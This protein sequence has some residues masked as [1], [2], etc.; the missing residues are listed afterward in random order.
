MNAKYI[1]IS[2]CALLAIGVMLPFADSSAVTCPSGYNMVENTGT[3]MPSNNGLPSASVKDIVEN[4]LKW[5]LGLF[6]VIG[7][8]AFVISG[9]MYL[10]AAG[11]AEQEKKAKNAMKVAI[12]GIIVG[13]A[14]YVAI[15]AV[16]SI[17]NASI[18]Y[19]N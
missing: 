2:L 3:C 15:I 19:N 1:Y 4:G 10:T 11:D 9:I 8:A 16:D 7:M 12:I 13:L 14:G 6:G 5:M 17:L 18:Q